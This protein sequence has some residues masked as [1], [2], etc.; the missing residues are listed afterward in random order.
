[1]Y[2]EKLSLAL[3]SFEQGRPAVSNMP[4]LVDCF[5][6]WLHMSMFFALLLLESSRQL[7]FVELDHMDIARP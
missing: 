6:D 7:A 2:G 3:G 1:M 5:L 4:G